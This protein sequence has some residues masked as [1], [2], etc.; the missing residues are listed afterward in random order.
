MSI[1]WY[2]DNVL[3]IRFSQIPSVGVRVILP[4]MDENLKKNIAKKP[5]LN[6]ERI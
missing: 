5:F 3:S 1:L 2:K 4:T 6:R